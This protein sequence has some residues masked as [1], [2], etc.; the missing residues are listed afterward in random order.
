MRAVQDNRLEFVQLLLDYGADPILATQYAPKHP[1]KL[2]TPIAE[3]R[4]LGNREMIALLE[5]YI[6]D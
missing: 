5:A 4:M 2:G 6:Q 3:A 1:T